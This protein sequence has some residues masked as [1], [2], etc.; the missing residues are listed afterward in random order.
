MTDE[1]KGLPSASA[2]HRYFACP[3]SWMLE[4]QF[5]DGPASSDATMG[6]RIHAVLAGDYVA[7]ITQEE[8]YIIERCEDQAADLIIATFGN[9]FSTMEVFTEERFWATDPI[10]GEELWSGKP[11]VVYV[12]GA[13]A[14]IIDYKTGR[15]SVEDAS[16]NFQLRCLVSLLHE[17]FAYNLATITVAIVQPLAG[18]PSVCKYEFDDIEAAMAEALD[19][20]AKIKTQGQRRVPS[21]N[22]CRYCKGKSHCPEARELALALPIKNAPEKITPDAIAATLTTATLVEFLNRTAQAE[23]VIE[24]CKEEAK[25]RLADG[26]TLPGWILKDGAVRETITNTELVASRFMDFATYD[27]L[28]PAI[29]INKTKLKDA[30]KTSTGKKGKELDEILNQLFANATE[31]KQSQPMLV[32]IK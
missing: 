6:N 2:A 1:R 7:D 31:T 15:G 26:D 16:K 32:K 13:D 9:Y 29:T 18:A 21:D 30:V 25:K 24:A 28:L 14:L 11:D 8:K 3:G 20:M 12:H 23:A 4:N 5:P 27:Q 19:L 10:T 22:S 17:K